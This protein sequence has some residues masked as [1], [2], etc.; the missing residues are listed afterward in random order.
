MKEPLLNF[1]NLFQSASSDSTAD[2][3]ELTSAKK[4]AQGFIDSSLSSSTL[5]QYRQSYQRW[6]D[7]CSRN[8][9]PETPASTAHVSACLALVAS[10]TQSVSAVEKL[11]SAIAFE[12]RRL[13]LPSPTENAAIGLLLRGIRRRFTV[14]RRPKKPLTHDLLQRM[15]DVLHRPEHGQDGL[16]APLVLWRT[17]WRAFMEFYTLGRFDDVVRLRRD[18]VFICFEPQPH[19]VVKFVGGKSDLFSEGSERVVCGHNPPS[20]YCPVKLTELYFRKLGHDYS[21]YLVPRSR[22]VPGSVV[23]DPEHP[24]SYT[25][26]LQD[27][28]ELLT[29]LGCNSSEYGEH[30]GKRGGASAAAAS[31]ISADALQRL[32]QWRS[33]R[34][35]L[36]YTDLDTSNRLKLSSYLNGEKL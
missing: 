12:H 23:A 29:Q 27:L 21:G 26:A 34:M 28:R 19:L 16:R 32:G 24:V 17:I 25:T 1:L 2:C 7:F 13:F 5:H 14:E 20:C 30:S 9:L 31:G 3:S 10:E 6:A 36:K 33:T 11:L 8:G 18:A 35:P 15:I 22:S 4:L